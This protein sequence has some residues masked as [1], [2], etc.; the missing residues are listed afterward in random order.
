MHNTLNIEADG[1]Q[2]Q[3]TMSGSTSVIEEQNE[4]VRIGEIRA[5]CHGGRVCM[6]FGLF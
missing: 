6:C 5:M 2:K 1:L 3:K 4:I